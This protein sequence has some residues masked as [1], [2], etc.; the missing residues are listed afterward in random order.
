MLDAIAARRSGLVTYGVTPPKRS[1]A[2]E[3][4]QEVARRQSARLH[5]LP[6]HG[7]VVYDLQ[8]ESARTDAPRPFPH[9]E[10][11]DPVE[12]AFEHLADVP[13]PKI[14]YRCVAKLTPDDLA[15]SLERMC[16]EP[17]ET[18]TVLVGA[19]SRR[20]RTRMLL[21]DAYALCRRVYADIPLGGVLI[22]E[23]HRNG[24]REHER[25][26]GKVASGCSFFVSQAVYSSTDTKDVLSDLHL[27]CAELERQVP[28]VLVT[29]TPCGS[30][31]TLTFLRW[32]G[33]Q[34]PRWLE[35]ELLRSRDMLATSVD[36]CA[37]IFADLWTY[38]T[39]RGIPLGCNVESVSLSRAEIDASVDLVERVTAIIGRR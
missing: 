5:A 19:A 24:H 9:E 2:A 16:A 32:L 35:N 27:S 30:E 1:W 7:A 6:L 13:L 17:A 21:S 37:D 8:D 15:R 25:A 11:V 20:Q 10:T 38:A 12:Y 22:A 36:L 3:R 28:P 31:R 29:L 34:V 33:V 26:L 39:D 14:V 23:R 18:A 4:I